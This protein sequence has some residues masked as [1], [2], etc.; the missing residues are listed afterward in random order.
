MRSSKKKIIIVDDV[1]YFLLSLKTR[2]GNQYEIY[3]ANSSVQLFDILENVKP[4]LII[5]DINMPEIDGFEVI[6]QLK[7][8]SRYFMI[9]VIFLTSSKDKENV[10]KAMALG[11]IDFR[12]KP[13][14][15]DDLVEC[16]ENQFDPERLKAN[17]PIILSV[18]DCPSILESINHILGDDYTVYSLPHPTRLNDVLKLTKPDLFLLDVQMPN[19][20]GFELVPII[21][22]KKDHE[23]T[24]I[25]FITS[26]ASVDHISAAITLDASDYIRKPLDAALLRERVAVHLKDY[27]I[28]RQLR[29]K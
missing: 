19:I 25:I 20:T 18:D 15:D 7:D 28:W 27:M 26:E 9:P 3:L 22:G 13:I 1:Q 4:D 24:P 11:A 23:N 12:F 5:L 16:I 29:T 14:N 8:D 2:L 6:K 17:K 21:R 10:H